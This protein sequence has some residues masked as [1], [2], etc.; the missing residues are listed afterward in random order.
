MP[1]CKRE[2]NSQISQK[3]H[4]IFFILSLVLVQGMGKRQKLRQVESPGLSCEKRNWKRTKLLQDFCQKE[5][6]KLE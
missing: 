5:K 2:I 1:S 6:E 3:Q 4:L